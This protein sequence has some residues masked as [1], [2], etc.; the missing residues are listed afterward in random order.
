M[1]ASTAVAKECRESLPRHGTQ[2]NLLVPQHS[3]RVASCRNNTSANCNSQAGCT[4]SEPTRGTMQWWNGATHAQQFPW[5]LRLR[6]PRNHMVVAARN[7]RMV[8]TGC[9]DSANIWSTCQQVRN[10]AECWRVHFLQRV[11]GVHHDDWANPSRTHQ[12]RDCPT[13]F[14]RRFHLLP[15]AA[16]LQKHTFAHHQVPI[17]RFS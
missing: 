11:Q 17:R 14:E 5:R 9:N 1:T 7:I 12:L 4:A 3:Q 8:C 2:S 6:V 16:Q 15:S 13:L 10:V